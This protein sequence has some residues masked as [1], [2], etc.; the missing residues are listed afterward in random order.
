MPVLT[1]TSAYDQ[2]QHY[3]LSLIIDAVQLLSVDDLMKEL[4][5]GLA[6]LK[7]EIDTR[8]GVKEVCQEAGCAGVLPFTA[9]VLGFRV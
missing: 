4:P 6:E 7:E 8:A 2:S 3:V 5:K 1:H 9:K